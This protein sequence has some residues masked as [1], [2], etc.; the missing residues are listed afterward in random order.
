VYK[1][2]ALTGIAALVAFVT[3][4]LVSTSHTTASAPKRFPVTR[5]GSIP[6]GSRAPAFTLPRL[7][8]GARVSLATAHGEPIM[9]NFFASWCTNCRREIAAV[10]SVARQ[11]QGKVE[12]IG[13]D[14]SDTSTEAP[15]K[16]LEEA[17]ATYPVGVDPEGKIATGRY[18]LTGL[19]V[20][21]F[22]SPGHTVVG[23]AF[24]PQTVTSLDRH[25]T[26]L[27]LLPAAS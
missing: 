1:V 20:T 17:G 10:A 16:L 5:P 13:I 15:E 24:G 2:V 21:F 12:T 22:L 19:P 4:A 3:V 23:V 9:L 26:S 7:G 6:V 8:G 27:H 18:G 14:T 11:M 25:L